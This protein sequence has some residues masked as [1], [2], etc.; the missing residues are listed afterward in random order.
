M[1]SLSSPEKTVILQLRISAMIH[2]G[3]IPSLLDRKRDRRVESVTIQVRETLRRSSIGS[4][5]YPAGFAHISLDSRYLKNLHLSA[6]FGGTGWRSL[7]DNKG[8]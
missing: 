6:G 4:P 3:T 7:S 1:N 2:W 8:A 5:P